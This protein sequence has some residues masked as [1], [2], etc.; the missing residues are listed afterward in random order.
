MEVLISSNI[1]SSVSI[2]HLG[3]KS[4]QNKSVFV[5]SIYLRIGDPII[6]VHF[7][8]TLKS[9]LSRSYISGVP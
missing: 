7:R 8:G 2:S 3:V 1:M 9:D 5:R 4:G 6:H